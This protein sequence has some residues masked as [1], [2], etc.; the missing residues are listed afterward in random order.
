MSD[1]D[2]LEY[3]TRVDVNIAILREIAKIRFRERLRQVMSALTRHL[4]DAGVDFS[5]VDYSKVEDA[6][7]EEIDSVYEDLF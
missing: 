3:T 2:D 5:K 7:D 6:T 4:I 1:E